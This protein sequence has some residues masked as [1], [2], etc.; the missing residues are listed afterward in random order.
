LNFS[1]TT[2]APLVLNA[3]E[4]VVAGSINDFY[5]AASQ[6]SD[7]SAAEAIFKARFEELGYDLTQLEA[8]NIQFRAFAKAVVLNP[9]AA[10]S[11]KI[12]TELEKLIMEID[13]FIASQPGLENFKTDPDILDDLQFAEFIAT[14]AALSA[15]L[16]GLKL[17]PGTAFEFTRTVA[18]SGYARLITLVADASKKAVAKKNQSS[19]FNNNL[20][21]LQ[22]FLM[23][24]PLQTVLNA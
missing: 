16:G 6:G 20:S 23:A 12:V 15:G 24:N 5:A 17:F 13:A 9:D 8:F 21:F 10:Q 11:V 7:T 1:A 3:A 19:K 4:Q 22:P 2:K 18:P 14:N